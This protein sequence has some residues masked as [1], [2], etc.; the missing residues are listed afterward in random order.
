[1]RVTQ[2]MIDRN[3][4][5]AMGESYGRLSKLND[6]LSTGLRVSTMSDDVPAAQQVLQL[7]RQNDLLDVYTGNLNAADAALGA[8]TTSLM[9]VSETVARVK[10]LAV[11]AATGTYTDANRDAMAEGVDS[12]LT[13]LLA[14]ANVEHN[15]GYVFSGE[16]TQ[17]APYEATRGPDGEI[18]AVTYRGEMIATEVAVG[19]TTRSNLNFVGKEVFQDNTDVFATV[20][21]LRDAI[22]ADDLDEVNRLIGE[23][24]ECHVEVRRSLGML[25]ERQAQLQ[26]LRNANES[27]HQLNEQ[28]ISQNQDADIAEVAVR[29]NSQLALLQMV[30]KVTAES[31]RPTLADFL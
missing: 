30:L 31:I 12:L 18:Q 9:K 14:M 19:P 10:E 15:G 1:M 29:Y 3:L 8:A 22:R 24:D 2:S 17:T 5:F 27:F 20:I 13:N 26:V 6:Q 4:V 23:L 7:Q 11:Q 21:A 16:S 25:G 28:L